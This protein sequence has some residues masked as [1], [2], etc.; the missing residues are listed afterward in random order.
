MQTGTIVRYKQHPEDEDD[1]GFPAIVMRE[2]QDGSLQLY[3]L[4]FDH[5]TNIR[6]AHHTQVAV[7]INPEEI[8]NQEILIRALL[9]TVA[10]QETRM[11][12]LEQWV[13]TLEKWAKPSVE[14]TPGWIDGKNN[15]ILPEP[16]LVFAVERGGTMSAPTVDAARAE[17]DKQADKADA[18]G[19]T[20]R[21]P[22]PK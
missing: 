1:T 8:E 20:K 15:E 16:E 13:G 6:A 21:K 17:L 18:V 10:S 11:V 7:M 5:P 4:Q 12:A 19:T 2:W 3:V 22:W 9:R 14:S